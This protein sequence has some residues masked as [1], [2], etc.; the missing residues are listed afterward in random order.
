M[1]LLN[2]LVE[3]FIDTFGITRPDPR[4]QRRVS[5]LLGGDGYLL[6][7]GCHNL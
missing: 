6:D 7:S 4:H 5:L 3:L 2:F 1:K